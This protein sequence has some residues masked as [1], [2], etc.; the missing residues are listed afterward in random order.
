M[1]DQ[2]TTPW[3]MNRKVWVAASAVTV[4]VA[5][6][7]GVALKNISIDNEG[8][9][10]EAALS[11]QYL[12]NQNVLSDCLITIRETA[13]VTTAQ[14]TTFEQVM[15]EAIKGRYAEIDS[16][17]PTSGSMF[18]AIVEQYP[19]LS[20]LSEAY[21][22][23]HTVIVGCRADYKNKQ[24]KLLDMLREYDAW[25]TGSWWVRTLGGNFPS[26]NLEARVGSNSWRGVDAR[27]KMYDIVLVQGAVQAYDDGTIVPLDPFGVN[28]GQVVESE[29]NPVSTP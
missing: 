2:G 14:A 6:I 11:A 4:I 29:P 12:D 19:D 28:E 22:R 3:Y 13:N 20:S 23:V 10:R 16:V 26:N 9:K 25:R 8:N 21:E 7:L 27:D 15:T 18:S 17:D 24:T 1:N 5:V